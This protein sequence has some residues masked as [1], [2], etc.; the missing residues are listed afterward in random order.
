MSLNYSI[1]AITNINSDK[2]APPPYSTIFKRQKSSS[3]SIVSGKLKLQGNLQQLTLGNT[4]HWG[5]NCK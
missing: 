5:Y 4:N 3:A 1:Y 2:L